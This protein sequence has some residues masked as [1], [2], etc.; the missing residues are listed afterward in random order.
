VLLALPH[1]IEALGCILCSLGVRKG[2]EASV[3][4]GEACEWA[5]LFVGDLLDRL[6]A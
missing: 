3:F 2:D 4:D 6:A 5:T 1:D